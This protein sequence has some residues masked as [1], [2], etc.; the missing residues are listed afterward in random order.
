MR[1]K[2]EN[3]TIFVVIVIVIA[4][5]FLRFYMLDWETLSFDEV[6][7]GYHAATEYIKGNFVYNFYGFDTPPL[8]KYMYAAVVTIAGFSD[9]ALRAVPAAFGVIAVA[10]TFLVAR[11]IYRNDEIAIM[12]ASLTGFSIIHIQFSR[13]V[14]MEAII[15]PFYLLS[16][17]FML[18]LAE[19]RSKHTWLFLGVTIALGMLIKYIML[20]AVLT[21]IIYAIYRGLIRFRK[22]PD[23]SISIDRDF[24]K[25][26]AI[27]IILFFLLW[28]F[29]LYPLQ[30]DVSLYVNHDGQHG[31]SLRLLVPMLF[32]T[33]GNVGSFAVGERAG[34]NF[35]TSIATNLPG[36]GYFLLFLVKENIIF[37]MMFIAGIYA[38]YKRRTQ[39]DKLAVLAIILFFVFLSLQRYGYTY[40]YVTAIIPI[41]AIMAA[42]ALRLINKNKIKTLL[43]AAFSVIMFANALAAQ[44]SYAFY[45]NPINLLASI[46]DPEGY[47]SEGTRAVLEYANNCAHVYTNY[48]YVV[49]PYIKEKLTNS[50]AT[51]PLCVF[52]G[53]ASTP[54]KADLVNYANPNCVL[55]KEIVKNGIK[56]FDVYEC[57]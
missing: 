44:P 19:K 25:T 6:M 31:G 28:P 42:G 26:I 15:T 18:V 33:F 22:R 11:R 55:K 12:A 21:I 45:Y 56:F 9:T 46:Q 1:P 14:V 57:K 29:A 47:Y 34:L 13:M 5:A 17:Y 40:R 8:G 50:T 32:L 20:Y 7:Y 41:M 54:G 39:A 23:I 36:L 2:L 43:I 10:L 48:D 53:R 49:E 3:K 52:I 37:V 24:V 27:S 30:T 51:R 4:A 38:A 16:L 35:A